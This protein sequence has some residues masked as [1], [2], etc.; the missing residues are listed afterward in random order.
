MLSAMTSRRLLAVAAA[1]TVA[2]A[3]AVAAYLAVQA[4]SDEP[5]AR[6]ARVINETRGT[7]RGV[8][9]GDSEAEVRRVLGQ[10]EPADT[11]RESMMPLNADFRAD[12]GPMV[13]DFPDKPAAGRHAL[14]R[15]DDVSFLFFDGEV[16]AV[17]VTDDGAATERGLAIGDDLDSV[18]QR[19]Q[20]MTCG[21]AEP[22]SGPFPYC[23][24]ALGRQRHIWFGQDPIGSITMATTPF[25]TYER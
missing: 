11:S 25:D 18:E 6:S 23:A 19:Y 10:A 9:I 12:G 21:D 15:Y 7:Y 16:F 5:A 4:G 17:V 14:L 13:I 1:A 24:G 2:I 8:G 20:R 22:E 3:V